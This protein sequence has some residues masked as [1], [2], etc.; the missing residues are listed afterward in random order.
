MATFPFRRAL[1]TG[2]S[3]GIGE[4]FAHILGGAGVPCVVVARRGDRLRELA[5]R[6]A[7]FEV[8]EADLQD[9]EGIGAVAARIASTDRKS[10]V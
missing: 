7:G 6:Y 3:A 9:D 5:D 2:A 4:R 1:V 8:L 10:V